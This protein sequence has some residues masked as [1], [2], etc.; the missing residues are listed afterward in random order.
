MSA[1]YTPIDYFQNLDKLTNRDWHYKLA[2]LFPVG[3]V[4]NA[5]RIIQVEVL[6]E[7][8]QEEF[9]TEIHQ[10]LKTMQVEHDNHLMTLHQKAD[11]NAT[12]HSADSAI[13]ASSP[14][15]MFF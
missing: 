11:H 14:M 6:N 15:K 12:Q 9:R 2:K 10:L 5:K 7:K 4:T 13:E 1:V 3:G 8:S